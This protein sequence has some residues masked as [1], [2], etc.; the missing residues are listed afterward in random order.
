MGNNLNHSNTSIVSLPHANEANDEEKEEKEEDKAFYFINR[1]NITHKKLKIKMRMTQ[2]FGTIIGP[3]QSKFKQRIAL[4][5]D[6]EQIENSWTPQ[7]LID[8]FDIENGDQ[9]DAC[10]TA[11]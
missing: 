1:P 11:L 8:E 6:G 10:Y 3:L 9:I 5:F 7:Y 2:E 4:S